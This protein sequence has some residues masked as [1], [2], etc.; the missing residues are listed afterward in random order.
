MKLIK[1][2]ILLAIISVCIGKSYG[3]KDT[4]PAPQA[5]VT[6]SPTPVIVE[7]VEEEIFST[8][9]DKIVESIPVGP[10]IVEPEKPVILPTH[11]P[12]EKKQPVTV[13]IQV[14]PIKTPAPTQA[15]TTD[16]SISVPPITWN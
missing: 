6:P 3:T 4:T 11:T 2:F 12:A 7:I 5:T 8:E 9:T 15:P 13:I 16:S 1:K 10:A 14:E